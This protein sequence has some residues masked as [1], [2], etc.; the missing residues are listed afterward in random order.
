MKKLIYL[1]LP[2]LFFTTACKKDLTSLNIE[3]KK[4]AAVPAGP[5]F[6]SATRQFADNMASASVN[7]NIWRF[8]VKHWAMTTYNDEVQFDYSTR[9]IPQTWWTVLYRDVLLDYKSAAKTISESTT[10]LAGVKAN[11]LAM[12]DIMQLYVYSVMVNTFGNIPYTQALDPEKNLLPVYDDAKTVYYDLMKRLDADIAAL[13]TG[14]A[15][16]AAGEDFLYK[17]NVSS[18]IKFANSIRFKMGMLLADSDAGAAKTAVEA[19]DAKAFTSAADN[20][21]FAYLTGTPNTNP[22]YVDIVLGG[23][24]DYVGA[25]D[26]I[27][28]MKA[29]NDPRVPLYFNKN[30]AG[31]YAGGTSGTTNTLSQFSQPSAKVTDANTPQVFLDYSE[32]EFLRAEAKERGFNVA[33][34]AETHYNNAVTASIVW[35]GGTAGDAATYLA[36]P[37]VAY[38]TAAGSYKQK[39]GTQKWIALYNRSFDGWLEYRRLDFPVLTLPVGAKS[40]YPNRFPYPNNEQQLNGDNYKA[41]ATAMGG[42]KVEYK[43][44]WDKN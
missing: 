21:Q 13:N 44:F 18:W 33:G 26:L 4:P 6:A 38:A 31:N 29:L 17:G 35:W 43:L 39:I 28:P 41:A 37:A 30:N 23:R 24:G 7:T 22:L 19:S 5:L 42:D 14:S 20:A 15:G 36:Q 8:A 10:L 27:D 32:M 11:Q 16:F 40:G 12:V 1:A 34:T 9:N 3:T 25:K 2:L